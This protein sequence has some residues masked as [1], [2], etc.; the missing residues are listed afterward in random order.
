MHGLPGGRGALV[1]GN[2]LQLWVLDLDAATIEEILTGVI[3]AWYAPTGHVVYVRADGAVFAQPFDLDALE[4]SGGAVPL[5]EGVQVTAARADM[6][7]AADGTLLYLEGRT[8]SDDAVSQLVVVDLDGSQQALSLS[9][10]PLT[11]P[12][13]S[14]DGESVAFESRD[15]IYL[16]NTVLNTTPRQIT[17]EGMNGV[18]VFSPDGRNLAFWRGARLTGLDVFVKELENDSPERPLTSLDGWEVPW[19]WPSD[20]LIA[21]LSGREGAYDLWTLDLSDPNA[22]EAR[23]YLTSEAD[24]VPIV[25][26]PDGTL[27]AYSSNETGTYEVY[28]RSF[29]NPGDRTVVSRGGGGGARWSPD[30]GTLYYDARVSGPG[31]TMVAARLSRGLVPAVLSTDTLFTLFT[32]RGLTGGSLHPDGD[33]FILSVVVD[34]GE[35]AEAGPPRLILVRNFFTELLERM[36]EAR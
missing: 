21:F 6:R 36:G 31:V 12:A 24:L 9:P 26:S 22:P 4:L 17:F 25:I 35:T 33:R 15:Q 10:R 8:G 20:T 30:G 29:P 7:L 32:D 27:A 5:F 16:Y 1:V 18:P 11:N 2:S 28:V 14:P 19:Q 13:W 23:P 3:R 34:G